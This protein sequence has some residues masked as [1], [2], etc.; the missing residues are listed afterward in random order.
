MRSK[1]V[2]VIRSSNVNVMQSTDVHV[3]RSSYVNV[4][5]SKNVH[6]I[7]SSNINIM[8]SNNVQAHEILEQLKKTNSSLE[9]SKIRLRNGLQMYWDG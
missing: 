7:R 5:R 2:H 6:V 4:M 3:I 9:I 8:R 1:N